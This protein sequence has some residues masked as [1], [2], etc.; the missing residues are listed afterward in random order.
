MRR[1][2]IVS[3]GR[4]AACFVV[5]LIAVAQAGCSGVERSE[6]KSASDRKPTFNRDI[7]PIVFD[8]CAACHRTDGSAPF[9]LLTYAELKDRGPQ[10][11]DVTKSRFM[12][13]WLPGGGDYK[14][15]GDCSLSDEQISTIQDWVAS[16]CI[17]GDPAELPPPPQGPFHGTPDLVVE[18]P[19]AYRLAADGTDVWRK[20]VM[21][22]PLTTP[23]YVRAV[24]IRPSN[25]RVVH[26]AIV[27]I[28]NSG[29]TR[30][31]AGKDPDLSIDGMT[32]TPEERSPDG[33]FLNWL[34]GMIPFSD[35][36]Q[37]AWQIQPLTD[38]VVETHMLP[39]GKPESVRLSVG[40]YFTDT[41]PSKFPVDF[42][43][44]S[45][46]IDI[47]AGSKDY[48][49]TDSYTLPVEVQLLGLFPHAHFL[50]KEVDVW[51]IFPDGT[52]KTLLR[53]PRWDFNWQNAYR[54]AEPVAL[55]L[56]TTL[57]M[58]IGYDNSVDNARNPHNPPRRVQFGYHSYDE[59]AQVNMDVLPRDAAAASRLRDDF[60]RHDV[61][62]MIKAYE[63]QLGIH[64]DDSAIHTQLGKDLVFTGH[65]QEGMSHL[66]RAVQL[67]P[68]NAEAHYH[69]GRF[70]MASGKSDAA[71]M[72]YEEAIEADPNYYL[73]VSELGLWHLNRGH[74]AEAQELLE[75]SLKI[76]P[77]DA[78]VL[79]NLGI[80]RSR[81]KKRSEAI[82]DFQQALSIDPNYLPARDNLRKVEANAE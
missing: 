35:D 33:H 9:R 48:A 54:F 4:F 51:A 25:K 68:N 23:R 46:C 70:E 73:A 69:L 1:R 64:P 8:H 6:A 66:H 74:L 38:L 49:V 32:S 57:A 80:V 42:L 27:H 61:L 15:S 52:K 5:T 58:R 14:F 55:P 53:I 37:M 71:R 79:N 40:L 60:V 16:G 47:P 43:L 30:A 62:A 12:P 3:S 56:G 65:L 31:L 28:D 20:F 17:E 82:H 44:H 22:V 26:H 13:P 72:E 50:G 24:E 2:T 67:D 76:H 45:D 36:P 39:S 7:A 59:M 21:R 75:R 78:V 18:M 11:A 10:I 81:Q 34:P 77:S 41:P 19:N 63:F 29:N